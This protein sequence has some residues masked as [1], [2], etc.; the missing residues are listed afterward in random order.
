[1]I[2]DPELRLDE[3]EQVQ[4]EVAS[5]L[6]PSATPVAVAVT[7]PTGQLT[8]TGTGEGSSEVSSPKV[9]EE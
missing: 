4:M 8:E 9:V 5:L 7:T 3:I 2:P 6:S 1:V